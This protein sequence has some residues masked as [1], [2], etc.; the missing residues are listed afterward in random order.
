MSSNQQRKPTVYRGLHEDNLCGFSKDQVLDFTFPHIDNRRY[1]KVVGRE[2]AA[3]AIDTS[4]HIQAIIRTKCEDDADEII[5]EL[6]FSY[7]TGICLKNPACVEHWAYIMKMVFQAFL[8]AVDEPEFFSK[9]IKAVHAQLIYDEG[10]KDGSVLDH[11]PNFKDDFKN[12]LTVFKSRLTD[13]LLKT[14][15]KLT[16]DQKNVGRAFEDL[17]SWLCRWNWDLRGNTDSELKEPETD[18]EK[19]KSSNC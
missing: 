5:G 18:V 9:F 2:Q 16:A 7:L 12:I 6:Q 8:I 17:E 3:Q 14:G 19:C 4:G 13:L 1:R 10:I 11:D 15:N